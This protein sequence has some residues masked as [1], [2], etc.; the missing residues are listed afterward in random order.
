MTAALGLSAAVQNVAEFRNVYGEYGARPVRISEVSRY[1]LS[2]SV[3]VAMMAGCGAL[4]LSLSQ[5]SD[6]ARP[7]I[8]A[9][10][11]Q[12]TSWILPGS[13]SGDLLY[14]SVVYSGVT[15]VYTYPGGKLVGGLSNTG[16]T[17]GLCSDKNGNVFI[18][19]AYAIYEYPHG[20]A[21]P[22]ATLTDPQGQPYSCSIDPATGKL[23]VASGGGVAVYS[24][25]RKNQW[26]LP[27]LFNFQSHVTSCTYD[28]AGNLFA[29]GPTSGGKPLFAVLR[30]GASKFDPLSL[31][32]NV[33]E[34]GNLEWDGKYLAIGGK[35][36]FVHRF[37]IHG[38]QG[39]QIGLVR[40][41]GAP[42]LYQFWIHGSTIIGPA[43]NGGFFVGFWRYPQGR[44]VKTIQES[45]AFGS[46]ISLAP[47]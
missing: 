39:T 16:Y 32:R 42:D 5:G 20:L 38:T 8:A 19:T 7:P 30:R 24:P 46:T 47:R 11:A 27:R 17:N 18:T 14:I 40:L 45:S 3:A 28:A 25:A 37:V 9:H 44:L 4:P 22:V 31:N 1:A 21:A 36:L 12:G 29:D 6:D 41:N 15:N 2:T 26:Y 34:P 43:Y 23:A 33:P 10:A 35:H 13:Q